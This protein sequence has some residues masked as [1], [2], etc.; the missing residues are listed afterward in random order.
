VGFKITFEPL[1]RTQGVGPKSVEI[2][3]AHDAWIEVHGL[4]NSDEQ[5]TISENGHPIS[6]LELRDRAKGQ[7]N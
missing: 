6:W 4:M 3:S 2:E 1:N 7:A 5:V